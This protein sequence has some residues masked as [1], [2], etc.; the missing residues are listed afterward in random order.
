MPGAGSSY[1]ASCPFGASLTCTAQGTI[2]AADC[3]TGGGGLN[4]SELNLNNCAAQGFVV[5][6][7]NGVLTCGGC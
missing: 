1:D 2:I 7:C 3:T 4:Y 5:S 6:N